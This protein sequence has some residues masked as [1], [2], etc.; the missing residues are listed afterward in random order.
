TST[1]RLYGKK[2]KPTASC[3]YSMISA[4]GRTRCSWRIFTGS[5]MRCWTSFPGSNHRHRHAHNRHGQDPCGRATGSE[6]IHSK[7]TTLWKNRSEEHT[8]E[9]QSRE[10]LVCR[11]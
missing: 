8:S 4:D 11:L 5:T 6:P 2:R 1:W 3:P 10:N 9:L 7:N